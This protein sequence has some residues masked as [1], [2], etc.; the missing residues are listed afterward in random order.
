MGKK[1]GIRDMIEIAGGAA[2]LA[3]FL[4]SMIDLFAGDIMYKT[5]VQNM[6]TGKSVWI[7]VFFGFLIGPIIGIVATFATDVI[8][9]K[10]RPLSAIALLIATLIN[11]ALWICIAY[12]CVIA[13]DASWLTGLN[14][15]ERAVVWPKVLAYFAVLILGS[16]VLLWDMS[17]VT[18]SILYVILL[19][20]FDVRRSHG[21]ERRS[22]RSRKKSFKRKKPEVR[23]V[24]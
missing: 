7:H 1:L 8:D 23:S 16:V 17:L 15:V 5:I 18:Q 10:D 22:K 3:V 13:E 12:G 20:V 6:E 4:F 9:R 19:K 11:Y 24:F 21:S 2:L 14:L